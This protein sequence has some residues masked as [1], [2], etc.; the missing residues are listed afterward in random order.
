MDSQGSPLEKILY[1]AL[2]KVCDC[3]LLLC[4]S[5][6]IIIVRYAVYTRENSGKRHHNLCPENFILVEFLLQLS[7]SFPLC[8]GQTWMRHFLKLNLPFPLLHTNSSPAVVA[9][10]LKGATLYQVAVAMRSH[11]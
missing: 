8:P 5:F 6:L 9:V 7:C 1:M 10:S 11:P 2:G 4:A 3:S